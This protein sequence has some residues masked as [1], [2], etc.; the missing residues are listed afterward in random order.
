MFGPFP[1]QQ[2][3]KNRVVLGQR[4]SIFEDLEASRP[5]TSKCVLEDSTFGAVHGGW[6]LIVDLNVC[7]VIVRTQQQNTISIQSTQN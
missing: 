3:K 5:R 1:I 6:E 7:M 4:Q 2:I